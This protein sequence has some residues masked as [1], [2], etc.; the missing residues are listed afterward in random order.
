MKEFDALCIAHYDFK[1]KKT[2]E[3]VK[4][5]KYLVSLG[6]FGCRELCY[7]LDETID[8]LEVVKVNLGYKNNKF[9]ISEVIK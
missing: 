1:D 2:N 4:K 3:N 8:L 7:D 5:N 9:F 6:E